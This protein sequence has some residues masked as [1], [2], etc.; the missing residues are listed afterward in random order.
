MAQPVV[1]IFSTLQQF[2]LKLFV[3]GENLGQATLRKV[4]SKGATRCGFDL[5]SDSERRRSVRV[6]RLTNL[7][8]KRLI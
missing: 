2:P 3:G 7:E 1:L 4:F 5:R 8:S 6:K